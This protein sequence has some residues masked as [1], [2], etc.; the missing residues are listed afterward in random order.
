MESTNTSKLRKLV[1]NKFVLGVI[2]GFAIGMVTNNTVVAIALIVVV[3][4]AWYSASRK[5]KEEEVA[6]E[7]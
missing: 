7:V 3:S 4:L 6:E 2:T 5:K 1:S